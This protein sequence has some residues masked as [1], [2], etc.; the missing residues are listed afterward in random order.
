MKAT[1]NLYSTENG[2]IQR[3]LTSFYNKK[4]DLENDL[5]SIVESNNS[6]NSFIYSVF[7]RQLIKITIDT[8]N[9][10]KATGKSCKLLTK[11]FVLILFIIVYINVI[12]ISDIA[13]PS[14]TKYI[15][16]FM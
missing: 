4:M 7:E 10:I 5:K 3:F 15:G 9:G 12:I 11:I 8:K 14:D 2:E 16:I 6:D 13:N 1:V